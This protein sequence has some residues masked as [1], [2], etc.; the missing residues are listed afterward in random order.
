[1]SGRPLWWAGRLT[2]CEERQQASRRPGPSPAGRLSAGSGRRPAA[3]SGRTRSGRVGRARRRRGDPEVRGVA[4][5]G[6]DHPGG[7]R[8]EEEADPR[9]LTAVISRTAKGPHVRAFC[10]SR[11]SRSERAQPPNAVAPR[12]CS[13]RGLCGTSGRCCRSD[14]PRSCR[15]SRSRAVRRGPVPVGRRPGTGRAYS[16]AAGLLLPRPS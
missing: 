13:L 8:G 12:S 9:N 7:V 11:P 5:A 1:M 15:R 10:L 4:G 3:G 2:W 16:L 14:N 6:P